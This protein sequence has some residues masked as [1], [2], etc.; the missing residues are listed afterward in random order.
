MTYSRFVLDRRLAPAY[1]RLRYPRLAE[2]TIH[3]IAMTPASVTCRTAS[4]RSA[5]ATQ[6]P[7]LTCVSRR[8]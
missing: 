6:S 1:R 2:R 3:S 8:Q 4:A 5:A 7:R